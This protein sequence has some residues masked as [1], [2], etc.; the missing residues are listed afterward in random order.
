MVLFQVFLIL[1]T[2]VNSSYTELDTI[3]GITANLEPLLEFTQQMPHLNA[4]LSNVQSNVNILQTNIT[5]LDMELE[6]ITDEII[7]AIETNCSTTQ[8]CIDMM[9]KVNNASVNVNFSNFD[10]IYSDI[11]LGLQVAIETNLS[12]NLENGY[13][14]FQE[15]IITV[16]SE[17][18]ADIDA[19]RNASDDVVVTIKDELNKVEEDV[20][21]VDFDGVGDD[22]RE[23]S[24]DDME[25]P[26][27][28]T[29]W[30]LVGFASV[31]AL[32]VLLTYLGLLFS[33]CPRADRE[34]D[35]CCTRK[36]AATCLLSGVGI[37]FIFFWILLLVLIPVFLT[38]GLTQTEICRHLV[39]L[40]DS[41]ISGIINELVNATFYEDTNFSINITEIYT[42]CKEN[43]AFYTALDVENTFGFDLDTLLDT[44][45]IDDQINNIR[46]T[47]VDIGQ[48]EI[49]NN[50]SYTL[51]TELGSALENSA[52]NTKN[53]LAELQKNVTTTD[54]GVLVQEL[55]DL[56]GNVSGDSWMSSIDKL[57]SLYNGSVTEINTLR[58]D[59]FVELAGV[60]DLL[61]ENITA[62][63]IG[64]YK[65]QNITNEQGNDIVQGVINSTATE[66]ENIIDSS[67]EEIENNVRYEIGKCKPVYNAVATIVDS[68]CV[69]LLYALNG[70][71]F[72]LGWSLFFLLI[73]II[74]SFK[75]STMYRKTMDHDEIIPQVRREGRTPR[76][77]RHQNTDST[78]LI[79]RRNSHEMTPVNNPVYSLDGQKIPRPQLKQ[80]IAVY[81]EE[82][83]H[84]VGRPPSYSESQ[85][86]RK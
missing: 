68:A 83:T 40:D 31:L 8:E 14:Q 63:T 7:T 45:A 2:V 49:L 54:L 81:P 25:F 42:S 22:L 26:A 78:V 41:P 77:Q 76:H 33:C 38:G 43:E 32:I 74:L 57:E 50:D 46:N 9:A 36:M 53:L 23:I 15:I 60:Q 24:N 18:S 19:A 12:S 71:W 61:T 17:V 55:R 73:S 62:I 5:D 27:Y 67:I 64:L 4:T 66:V 13:E 1:D 3:T 56:A 85:F 37:A 11:L 47:T 30:S 70:Y 75:L 20:G 44:E 82:M 34:S 59:I 6:T 58:K 52:E 29:F 39:A 80:G 84:I 86:I 51:L 79:V 72:A 69:E 48:I 28:V 10:N 35:Y 65:G 16:D 21:S